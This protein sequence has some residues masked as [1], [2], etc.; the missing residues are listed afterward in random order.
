[1]QLQRYERHERAELPRWQCIVDL[2]IKCRAVGEC[3]EPLVPNEGELAVGMCQ[4]DNNP[5]DS[6]IL[7]KDGRAQ[8]VFHAD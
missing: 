2:A 4:R 6:F 3:T 1:L 5:C 7:V 8:R